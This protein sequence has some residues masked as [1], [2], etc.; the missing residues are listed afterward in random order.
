MRS[1]SACC[2]N[3]VASGSAQPGAADPDGDG[4]AA[5]SERLR[6]FRPLDGG[7][8][9]GPLPRRQ[10]AAMAGPSRTKVTTGFWVDLANA[11]TGNMICDDSLQEVRP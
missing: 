5:K 8:A 6:L 4:A 7:S 10:L 1:C 3:S 2:V 9:A 11:W